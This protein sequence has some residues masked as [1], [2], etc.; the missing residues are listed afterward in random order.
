MKFEEID[1]L[2]PLIVTGNTA[3]RFSGISCDS[4]R[5][6][7]GYL[8]AAVPGWK[9]DGAK[10]VDSALERG[11]AGVITEN[12]PRFVRGPAVQVTDVRW[13]LALIASAVNGYPSRKMDVYSVTGTN[14]KTTTAWLLREILTGSGRNTGL[15][16]TVSIEYPGREIPAVR[17]T[18]DACMLQELLADMLGA[19][20]DSVVMESSS[21]ALCQ[22]R[23][24]GIPFAGGAFT[25]LSRD[26]LDY[27]RTMDEYFEAKLL[28]FKQM[29]ALNPGAPAVC[30]I[31]GD[32]GRK[33][34]REIEKLPLTCI[35]AGFNDNAHLR[36]SSLTASALNSDFVLNGC[37]ADNLKI[38]TSL[39]GRYN[40][41][42]IMCASALAA[43]AGVSWRKIA[44][45]VES[46]CPRWG[47]L[48]RVSLPGKRISAFVDYAHTD[49]ALNNVLST[50]REIT[51]G[52]LIV[53]FGC[54]GDRD[55]S[56][57]PLM[58]KTCAEL[59]DIS[60]VT[61][62][63][64]R[65]EEPMKIISEIMSGVSGQPN[66]SVCEDRREAIR[67]ALKMAADGDV[68][69]VAGKGH[70]CFQESAG[71]SVPFDDR[72]VL[73]EEA[74]LLQVSESRKPAQPTERNAERY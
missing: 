24:A 71:R 65:S 66:V 39:A 32:Y 56:K 10:Y 46:V 42:N 34:A 44:Q 64:P 73:K 53:V 50:L 16:S 11:A 28:M 9:E 25:N 49:D 22:S 3:I 19:G 63:N 20:C 48:E 35:T 17:T 33:M 54:G 59:A 6:R 61:S 69:L 23:G 74:A 8:F 37:G 29:A 52:K 36:A 60:V 7:P 62:D 21:H 41:L 72:A 45:T 68:L 4:R 58:G 55:I 27:H 67:K 43:A 12:S 13:A 2:A 30:C 5:I 38:S 70:E 1:M 18:P 26:H 14:G 40:V 57:R 15:F 47:R 31:D 51:E